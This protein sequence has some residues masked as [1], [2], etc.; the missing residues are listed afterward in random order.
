MPSDLLQPSHERSRLPV[1]IRA[2]RSESSSH[3]GGTGKCPASVRGE[4]AVMGL[5]KN[6]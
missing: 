4:K 1:A 2:S 5:F 6:V 3:N